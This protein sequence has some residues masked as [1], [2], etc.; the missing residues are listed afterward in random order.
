MSVITDLFAG[1]TGTVSTVADYYVKL[2]QVQVDQGLTSQSRTIDELK[3]SITLMQQQ[4]QLQAQYA[5]QAAVN[6]ADS[7]MLK[8]ALVAGGLLLV[9]KLVK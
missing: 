5:Q 1:V 7:P 4:A 2:N 8:W 6:A 3:N 9:Y